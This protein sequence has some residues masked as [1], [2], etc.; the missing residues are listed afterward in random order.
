LAAVRKGKLSMWKGAAEAMAAKSGTF[1]ALLARAGLTGPLTIFE[2]SG[3]Y[4]EVVS[5]VLDGDV[6]RKRPEEFLLLT[7]CVKLW[8]CV[9]VAQA[10]IAAALK[11][12]R[13]RI[14]S[15]DEIKNIVIYLSAFSYEQQKKFLAAGLSTRE[16]ADHSA[17]YCVARAL[18]DGEVRLEHFDEIS[19]TEPRALELFN[20]V[21]LELGPGLPDK[22]G[23]RIEVHLH[24]GD[25]FCEEVLYPPGHTNNPVGQGA[26]VEKFRA[27]SEKVLG[28]EKTDR[29][30]DIVLHME[31][32]PNGAALLDALCPAGASS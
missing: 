16:S 8:P 10:P 21:S 27:L 9:F 17:P 14:F 22:V 5:G 23:A 19:F 26:V 7:S 15:P 1:A 11:L 32:A 28:S 31:T 2:G 18:L 24:N 4:R 12:R 25:A 13:Q 30:C 6:L 20:K 29:V 3:G